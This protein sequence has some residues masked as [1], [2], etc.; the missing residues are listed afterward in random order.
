MARD[1]SDFEV[2]SI[3]DDYFAMLRGVGGAT[4]Q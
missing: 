4:L 3:I 1:W 2:E